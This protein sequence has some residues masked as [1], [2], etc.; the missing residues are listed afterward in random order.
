MKYK[1]DSCG[2][3]TDNI[4]HDSDFMG[5]DFIK[6]YG[7]KEY[8]RCADCDKRLNDEIEWENEQSYMEYIT[9][10]WCGYEN[11]DSWEYE[12]SENE[13]KC[14]DCGRLFDLEI[15]HEVTYTTKK[16]ACERM[17]DSHEQS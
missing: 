13:V 15:N 6:K 2:N 12:D 16:S 5:E 9:C 8:H 14:V 7:D 10:P 3:S 17:E 4:Y 11:C 1:C